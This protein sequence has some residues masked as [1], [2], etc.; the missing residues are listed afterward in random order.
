MVLERGTRFCGLRPGNASAFS[1]DPRL[2]LATWPVRHCY[3]ACASFSLLNLGRD[4]RL[5]R[6]VNFSTLSRLTSQS[7][8]RMTQ[9]SLILNCKAIS[10]YVTRP[11][12]SARQSCWRAPRARSRPTAI[13]RPRA[14]L[15]TSFPVRI[16][17]P[18]FES[19]DYCSQQLYLCSRAEGLSV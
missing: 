9:K 19:F 16:F 12:Q 8:T 3:I 7:T 11:C 10:E 14:G 5:I 6:G 17:N 2:R 15:P 13:V 18:M 4:V 1:A